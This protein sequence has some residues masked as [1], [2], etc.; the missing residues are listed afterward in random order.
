MIYSK[1][2]DNMCS[3][4]KGANH[5]SAPIPEEGKYDEG[6][7][8]GINEGKI[9]G[10]IEQAKITAFNLH[11]AGMTNSVIAKMIGYAENV[12]AG[13]LEKAEA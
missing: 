8:E 12:V 2:I 6:I 3:V 1:D 13:W 9:E 7:N 11:A 5:G 4:R 10:K